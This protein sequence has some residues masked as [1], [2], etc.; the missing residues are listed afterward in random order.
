MF[1][2]MFVPAFLTL[3]IA[4]ASGLAATDSPSDSP[5]VKQLLQER[6][7]ILTTIYKARVEAHK[8]GVMSLDK[9]LE[10][11]AALLHAKLELCDTKE[12]RLKVHAEIVEL[13]RQTVQVVEQLSN[14]AEAPQSELLS[15]RL[16][17]LEA[18][19]GWERA[20]TRN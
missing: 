14:A 16:R 20:K 7:E 5:E 3:L 17:L 13:A 8:S 4:V 12:E 2:R 15:A 9:V 19:I 10:A 18:R 6:L 1:S 11:N